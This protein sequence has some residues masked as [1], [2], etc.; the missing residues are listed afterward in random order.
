MTNRMQYIFFYSFRPNNIFFIFHSLATKEVLNLSFHSGNIF[1]SGHRDIG[2]SLT[3]NIAK[4][5]TEQVAL[6]FRLWNDH[7]IIQLP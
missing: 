6:S 1:E 3:L 4:C 5:D 2:T 7:Q